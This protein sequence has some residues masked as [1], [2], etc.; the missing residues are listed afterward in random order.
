MPSPSSVAAHL[1]EAQR[2][3][4]E[5]GPDFLGVK[6]RVA[7]LNERLSQG[8]FRL[9][10]LGQFKRGKSTLLNAL[11]GEAL[12]PAG[13]LPLTAVP[14]MLR[15]G[16][17]RLIRIVFTDGREERFSGSTEALSNVLTQYATEHGNPSN[18]RQVGEITVE[19]PCSMLSTRQVW[20]QRYFRIPRP[21]GPHYRCAMQPLSCCRLIPPSPKSK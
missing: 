12:L 21:P 2:L 1:A 4:G 16:P 10:V 8:R 17:E 18:R 3:F 13:I 20:G 19:H 11:L 7:E 5:M 14:T 6:H 9:A 15:P